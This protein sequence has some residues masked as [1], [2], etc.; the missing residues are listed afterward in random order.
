LNLRELGVE[1]P[2]SVQGGIV[3]LKECGLDL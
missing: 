2:V 3:T 1:N